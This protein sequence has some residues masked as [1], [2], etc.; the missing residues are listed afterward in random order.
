MTVSSFSQAKFCFTL[1]IN[2]EWK[3]RLNYYRDG[4]YSIKCSCLKNRRLPDRKWL[5]QDYFVTYILCLD[6]R[7][8]R[9]IY[10]CNFCLK[11]ALELRRHR[12]SEKERISDNFV[13]GESATRLSTR[14]RSHLFDENTCSLQRWRIEI[15]VK[16]KHP[17]NQ[18][19]NEN[20]EE[21]RSRDYQFINVS[22]WKREREIKDWLLTFA[23]RL[24]PIFS[25]R[26][27]SYFLFILSAIFQCLQ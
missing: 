27:S 22:N 14:E 6:C 19:R 12:T 3:N 26:C 5:D 7:E 13:V 21:M 10:A 16:K 23:F 25:V 20:N 18:N 17:K 15:T 2:P 1:I 9:V 8:L 11:A 24:T 4:V